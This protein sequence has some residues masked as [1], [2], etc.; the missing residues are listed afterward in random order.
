MTGG[1]ASSLLGIAVICI[2][3]TRTVIVGSSGRGKVGINVG[4]VL[5][6]VRMNTLSDGREKK[7]YPVV[8]VVNHGFE[9]YLGDISLNDGVMKIEGHV[10]IA[11]GDKTKLL[12]YDY[13]SKF[14]RDANIYFSADERLDVWR[15]IDQN[16]V[17]DWCVNRIAKALN[18]R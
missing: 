8:I 4:G 10:F 9:N 2:A 18:D 17:P 12:V 6:D 11:E 7:W 5:V 3:C 15:A 16:E 13:G 1:Q 14:V